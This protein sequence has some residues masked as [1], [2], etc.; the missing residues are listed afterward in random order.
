L[1]PTCEAGANLPLS[2]APHLTMYRGRFAPSPTGPL[3]FGSLVAALG[4]YLEARTHQGEWLVRIEDLDAPRAVLGAAD[5]IL[6]TLETFGFCWDGQIVFQSQRH[7]AYRGALD[8]LIHRHA[9]YACSCSRSELL[10]LQTS[11]TNDGDDLHY[12][13]LC[14]HGVQHPSRNVAW[15][16][17]VDDEIIVFEDAAQGV[18]A[19]NVSQSVGDFVVKRRDGLYAYQLAVV[20]DDAAQG[21]THVVRGCDLLNSTPRQILLQRLLGLPTPH[22]LHLPV[23]VDSEGKKL[24]K[25]QAAPAVTADNA[26]LALYA[27]LEHLQQSPP[28]ELAR[29][30][31]TELWQWAQVHWRADACRGLK[32]VPLQSSASASHNY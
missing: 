31:L 22:Y 4:S 15:R 17:R 23:I 8:H 3:H 14:R 6:R 25:S 10:A 26:S 11:P 19:I 18:Q 16:L 12:P 5:D 30:S 32:K 13:G 9:A 1:I 7:E 20:V 28:A 21:I 24:S 27:A 2:P 29:V